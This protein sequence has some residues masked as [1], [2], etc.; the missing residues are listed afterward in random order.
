MNIDLS[1]IPQQSL[2]D[3][4]ELAYHKAT[5]YFQTEEGKAFKA[6]KNAEREARQAD[7]G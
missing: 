6:K 1:Q 4:S 3:L 7:K 5:A 2:L